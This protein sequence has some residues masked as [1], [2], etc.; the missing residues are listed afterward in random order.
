MRRAAIVD[1]GDAL[2]GVADGARVMI[3]GWGNLAT[4]FRLI[5]ALR[6]RGPRNL[7]IIITGSGPTESLTEAGLASHFVTTFG[8]YAGRVGRDSWFDRRVRED[9]MTV[10]LCSQ[11][12]LAER[13]RAG[14]AGIPAFYVEER[15]V[16][17][18]Q[19]TGEVREIDGR[20]CVLETAL[21]ADVAI[22]TASMADESGNLFWRDGERNFNDPMAY[23]ADLVVVETQELVPVGSIA[24]EMV[25]VPGLF[26]DR[27][28]GPA[29]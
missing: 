14:G 18:F 28:V 2:D 17:A 1:I 25:M 3:G 13:I 29:S 11:G 20:R 24:P 21:R 27:I 4:P 5:E 9:G 23:A 8:T 16:G 12:M 19:S 22:I 15:L 26:V 7:T 10:E 6:Q